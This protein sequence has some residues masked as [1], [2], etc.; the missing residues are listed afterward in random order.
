MD[1]ITAYI[2]KYWK[3]AQDIERKYK[4]PALVSISQSAVETGW[5]TSKPGNMMFG[6]KAGSNWKGATQNL[7]T[8][9]ILTAEQV[10]KLNNVQSITRLES[11]KYKVRVYQKFR[12]YP[13]IKASFEDYAKLLTQSS[14]YKKAFATNNPYSFAYE[15][16]KAGY[17]TATNYYN[18]LKN[19]MDTIKKKQ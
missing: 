3:Y 14:R 2:N 19:I 7:L 4:I 10:K 6:I 15:I 12:A 18:S 9:E 17:A 11:N 5:G 13:S 8:T 16:A 1:R